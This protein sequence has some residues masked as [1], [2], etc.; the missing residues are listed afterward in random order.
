MLTSGKSMSS[1][2]ESDG[3]S[4]LLSFKPLKEEVMSQPA[5][6]LGPHEVSAA[7]SSKL[8]L[9]EEMALEYFAGYCC[10]RLQG[11]H[12]SS[13]PSCSQHSSELTIDETE[14]TGMQFFLFLKRYSTTA[15]T[16]FKCTPNFVSYIQAIMQIS[17]YCLSNHVA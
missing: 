8:S 6:P 17:F 5:L 15:A 11:L 10:C 2:C 14:I 4:P 1:N 9:P 16:L 13:R 12:K 3:L 7:L